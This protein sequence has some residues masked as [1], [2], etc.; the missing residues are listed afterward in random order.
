[1]LTKWKDDLRLFL[2]SH[3]QFSSRDEYRYHE[4]LVHPGLAALP[5]ARRVLVLG[6]GDGLAVR[7]IL[8]YPTVESITL[9]DLDPEMTHLFSTHPVLSALNRHS[10]T[11]PRVH[12]INADAFRWLDANTEQFDFIVADFPDP[13][14]YS[15]GKLFTTTFYRLAAKHLSARR[16]ARRPKHLAV[17]RAPIVLVHRRNR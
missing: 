11:A 13:T 17:V 2:N 8:K 16:I 15:L 12:V 3:L 5:G 14:N 1:M 10:L 9:V 6:G 7:E 4:A